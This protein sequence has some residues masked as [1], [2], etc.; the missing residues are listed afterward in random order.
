[1]AN[2]RKFATDLLEENGLFDWSISFERSL[3][4]AG[5]CRYLQKSICFNVLFLKSVSVSEIRNTVF[6][7]VAHALAGPTAGHEEKW[8]SICE[9]L[10]GNARVVTTIPEVLASSE[11]YDWIGVCPNCNYTH[12][13]VS[14]PTSVWVC[15]SCSSTVP[16]KERIFRWYHH[17]TEVQ[18]EHIGGSFSLEYSNY[19]SKG[20]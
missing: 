3:V 10:G 17:Q 8:A 15:V 9:Q 18:P 14:V 6:H 4:R 11:N 19:L 20:V 12:G 7:E 13:S 5:T 2:V 16:E 1:M